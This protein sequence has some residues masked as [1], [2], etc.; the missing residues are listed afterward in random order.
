MLQSW[1]HGLG[2]SPTQQAAVQN[3][4]HNYGKAIEVLSSTAKV[5]PTAPL[6]ILLGKTEIKA[7]KYHNAV[8]SLEKAL[9]LMVCEQT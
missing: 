3:F 9:E 5:N 8:G 2:S 4:L 6:Y 7:K 1:P